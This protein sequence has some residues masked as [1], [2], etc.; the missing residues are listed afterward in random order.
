V[1]HHD[2]RR[3]ASLDDV[4]V[5]RV[6]DRRSH[7]GCYRHRQE[8]TVDAV[9]LWQSE[10]DV[11][12]AAGRVDLELVA[13]ALDQPHDLHAGPVDRADRHHERVDDDIGHRDPMVHGAVYDLLRH[14]ET[15]VRVLGN[16]GFVV[17]DGHDGCVVLLDER[18]HRLESFFLAGH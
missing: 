7:A 13:Q 5:H 16:A 9:T 8:S 17:R 12:G 10:A 18:Q 14:F 6:R 1:T 4:A 3:H 11:G 15:D 2:V